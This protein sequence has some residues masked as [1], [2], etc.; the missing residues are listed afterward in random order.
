[1]P[2]S[3]DTGKLF[4]EDWFKE[5]KPKT[6]LDVGTGVGTYGKI[7]KRIDSNCYIEG[8]EVYTPYIE[9]YQLN[10]IYA[11]IH[12]IEIKKLVADNYYDLIIFG[13]VL[14]HMTKEDAIGIINWFKKFAKFIFISIPIRYVPREWSRGYAQPP[15]EYKENIWEKHLHNWSYEDFQKEFGPFLWQ[16]LYKIVGCFVIEGIDYGSNIHHII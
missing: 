15:R 8:V 4:F 1:M 11:K 16:S 6:V 13:D 5:F 10:M 14:E 3:V 12:N 2:D 7:I 9:M